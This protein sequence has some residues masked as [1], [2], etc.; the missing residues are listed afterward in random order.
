MPKSSRISPS[1]RSSCLRINPDVQR[2]TFPQR[3]EDW[4]ASIIRFTRGRLFE[5]KRRNCSASSQEPFLKKWSAPSP[6][7]ANPAPP[8]RAF[9]FRCPSG[10]TLYGKAAHQSRFPFMPSGLG[11][12]FPCNTREALLSPRRAT[13]PQEPNVSPI[14]I[15][16]TARSISTGSG[17]SFF[18]LYGNERQPKSCP[19]LPTSPSTLRQAQQTKEL[20]PYSLPASRKPQERGAGG[21]NAFFKRGFLPR[22]HSPPHFHTP[23]AQ[24][25]RGAGNDTLLISLG[26]LDGGRQTPRHSKAETL[27]AKQQHFIHRLLA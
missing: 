2:R 25:L 5:T 6:S 14:L 7:T 27:L 21:G 15:K 26:P 9:P 19:P 4:L 16:K 8:Q 3:H 1:T 20:L 10:A 18:F 12:L 17:R 22:F 13:A 24:P 23:P 11:P